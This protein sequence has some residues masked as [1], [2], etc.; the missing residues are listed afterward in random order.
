MRSHP[1]FICLG[2][3]FKLATRHARASSTRLLSSGRGLCV[4]CDYNRG[5]L[6]CEPT[7]RLLVSVYGKGNLAFGAEKG[8]CQRAPT[9][10]F[11]RATMRTSAERRS[12]RRLSAIP[13]PQRSLGDE[14]R[15]IMSFKNLQLLPESQICRSNRVQNGGMSWKN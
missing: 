9:L 13:V 8:R 4:R 2:L 11:F 7:V 14:S 5:S 10:F 1:L 6:E 12:V 15:N 3:G